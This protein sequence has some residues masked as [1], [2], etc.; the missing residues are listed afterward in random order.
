MS[1]RVF[2]PLSCRMRDG[3][4]L[5]NDLVMTLWRHMGELGRTRECVLMS[6]RFFDESS[7]SESEVVVFAWSASVEPPVTGFTATSEMAAGTPHKHGKYVS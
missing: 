6:F 5:L 3:L 7:I 1:D 4:D 2:M